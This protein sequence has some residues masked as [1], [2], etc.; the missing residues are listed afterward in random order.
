MVPASNL[1]QCPLLLHI[2][3]AFAKPPVVSPPVPGCVVAS[4]S[5][6]FWTFHCDQS[7]AGCSE[8]VRYGLAADGGGKRNSETSSILGVS[9]IFPG[10][11]RLIG[12]RCRLMAR[13]ASLIAVPNCHF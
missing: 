3:T 8:I 5:G 9:T 7:S 6:S 10:L 1:R 13:N 11:K 12:S 2:S 4:L